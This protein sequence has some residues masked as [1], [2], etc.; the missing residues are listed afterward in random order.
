VVVVWPTGC[1]PGPTP[2]G[3]APVSPLVESAVVIAVLVEVSATVDAPELDAVG[4]ALVVP[5]PVAPLDVLPPSPTAG[6][7]EPQAASRANARPK[8]RRIGDQ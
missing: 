6:E 7:S 3:G 5:G 2:I 8:Q 1:G 4:S